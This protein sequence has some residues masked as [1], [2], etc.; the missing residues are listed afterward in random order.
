ML[1]TKLPQAADILP[2]TEWD[3]LGTR[4]VTVVL[5]LP[6]VETNGKPRMRR[7]PIRT[8]TYHEWY[9]IGAQVPEPDIPRTLL[10]QNGAKIPNP[11][12]KTYLEKRGKAEEER[13]FRRL[14]F[15]L[16]QAGIIVPGEATEDKIVKMK[17][18]L[19]AGIANALLGFLKQTAQ[20]GQA[21]LLALADSF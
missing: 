21:R 2:F 8:L 14:I 19:D 7:L 10:D 12:D 6:Y 11:L 4:I 18:T 20:G 17:D 15:A 16:E 13:A 9:S 5:Q 3:D 1:Q